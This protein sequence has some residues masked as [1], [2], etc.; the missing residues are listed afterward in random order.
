MVERSMTSTSTTPYV[1]D[2]TALDTLF[3]E[4]RTANTFSDE[5][6]TVEEV[7]AVHDLFRLGPTAMNNQP[8]RLMLVQSPQA[9]ERLVEH[10]SGS[11]KAKTAAAPLVAIVA[12]DEAFHER[13]GEHFPH[14]PGIRSIFDD[15]P[16]MRIDN[17]RTNT[18]IQ[19]GYFI[20]AL[21][22]TGL[23][24]GP[25]AGFDREGVDR[26]FLEGTSW[27]SQYVVNIGHPGP[28]AWGDR[29]PRISFED[30]VTVV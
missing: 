27:R 6:V 9:R 21:R 22:A 29:L 14:A 3:R 15:D 10:M 25:M 28:D 19:L 23:A 18:A 4:A 2:D 11:N 24:A 16:E 7:R 5:P 30:A 20:L 13:L 17:A 12:A 1:V 8:L 26:A